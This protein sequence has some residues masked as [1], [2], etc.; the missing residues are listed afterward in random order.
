LDVK[1]FA[2]GKKGARLLST[3]R[4]EKMKTRGRNTERDEN[5]TNFSLKSP[6]SC[7]SCLHVFLFKIA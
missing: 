1:A 6:P 5:D 7:I 3:G 4:H 2:G